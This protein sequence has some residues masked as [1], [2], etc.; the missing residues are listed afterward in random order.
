MP[1]GKVLVVDDV[2]ENRD[3]LCRRL[4]QLGLTFATAQNG[5][6]ALALLRGGTAFDLVLLDIMMPEMDGIEALGE[7]KKEDALRHLPVIMISALTDLD[8]VVKCIELGADD[9]LSKPFNAVLLRARIGAC[10]EKKRWR[11]REREYLADIERQ[12]ARTEELLHVIL[13]DEIVAELKATSRVAPRRHEKVAVLFC[14]IVGFT[15]YCD[16]HPPEELIARLQAW[17]DGFEEIALRHGLEK[18]KTIGDAFMTTAGLL[19][20]LSNPVLACVACGLEMV[21]ASPRLAPGWHVRVGIHVGPVIAGV[22]GRRQYLFDV[23]GDTVNTA[24]RME[25]VAVP[26]TVNVSD[27]AWREVEGHCRGRSR[28]VVAVKGKGDLETFV[29][30]GLLSPVSAPAEKLEARKST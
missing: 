28:G 26:N 2:E 21:E 15:S 3:I 18:I 7:M 22:V 27:A 14:D 19:R 23:W 5:R 30:E 12:K 11:D 13:P 4:K 1:P 10:L 6:E 8:S 9:Y 17:V 20:P 25:S 24:A 29:V 16:Q